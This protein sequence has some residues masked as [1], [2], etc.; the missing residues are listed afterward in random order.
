MT[1]QMIFLSAI[2]LYSLILIT[3][4]IKAA[5]GQSEEGFVIGS[6]NVG[7]IPTMGSLAA[8]FRDGMGAVFWSGIAYTYGY[9]GLWLI[10]GAIISLFFLSFVGPKIR[11]HAEENGFVT[12]GDF[13]K[14][15]LGGAGEKVVSLFVLIKSVL[16]ISIQLYVIGIICANVFGVPNY[17]GVIGTSL[18]IL[19]YLYFGGYSSVVK[20][21]ALQFFMIMGL[22][23]VPF[24]IQPDMTSVLDF[25]T[26][27]AMGWQSSLG[28]FIIGIFY[29]IG[30]ADT[31]QRLF[32]A[33][34][35]SVIRWAFP[36]SGLF[37]LVMTLTL[38]AIGYG[39]I[40]V[41][42]G[43]IEPSQALFALFTYTEAVN[44]Y[45]LAFFGVTIMAI[46]M[47]TLDT[48][49]YVFTSSF[50]RNFL[51]AQY[52]EN[53]MSYVKIS[54]GLIAFL[55]AGTA[56]ISLTIT[57]VIQFLFDAVSLIYVIVPVLLFAIFGWIKPSVKQDIFLTASIL[58]AA[59]VYIYMFS[60]GGFVNLLYNCIPLGISF[61][62]CGGV[63]LALRN[64][65]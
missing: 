47:S 43:D 24:F 6:R 29:V 46:S 17:Y 5:R 7:L 64:S 49:A 44:P 48:E 58:V 28:L 35:E 21:D 41:L 61:V 12:V 30:G 22:I 56:I 40:G 36:L 57:D 39:M 13:L 25:S 1:P 18:V 59:C 34:D 32:S 8:S 33:R 27:N 2:I 16:F 9:G 38:I 63:A 51:P 20:T 45:V 42:P 53:R 54:K 50:V 37:L 10:F 65:D 3:I 26:I 62:L 14:N 4:G 55:L 23:A 52:S 31:W 19:V 60:T 15:K 11:N